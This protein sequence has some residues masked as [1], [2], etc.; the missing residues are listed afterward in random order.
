MGALLV[1][2]LVILVAG[3]LGATVTSV[4]TIGCGVGLWF[5]GQSANRPFM[6]FDSRT[7]EQQMLKPRNTLFF[8]PLQYWGVLLGI[9]GVVAL[10]ST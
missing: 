8:I 9:S 3:N 1:A 7:G 4:A 6:G 2:G 10:F 5:Y